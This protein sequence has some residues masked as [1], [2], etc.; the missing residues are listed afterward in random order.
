MVG[1]PA[2]SA[3]GGE[4]KDIPSGYSLSQNYPNPFNPATTIR[5]ALPE[6]S[7]VVLSV[8]TILGERVAEL[9]NRTEGEGVHEIRF[10]ATSLSSGVYVYL[11]RAGRFFQSKNLIV[12]R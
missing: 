4:L 2:S 10:D 11:L 3:T 6:R 1:S 8:Y 7:H 12:I 9:V 5:Y